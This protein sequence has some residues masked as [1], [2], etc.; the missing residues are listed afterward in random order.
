MTPLMRIVDLPDY[1][2]RG[3]SKMRK[4]NISFSVRVFPLLLAAVLLAVLPG[5]LVS[6]EP[7]EEEYEPITSQDCVTCHERSAHDT[8][9]TDD[10]SHSIHEGLECL[11]CHVDRGTNPHKENPEFYVGCQGCRTCHDQQSEE[12]QAHGRESYGDCEDM[13]TCADCHGDHDVLPSSV[14]QAKT[15][16]I[17]LPQT[18]GKCHED[19]DITAKYEILIDHPIEIYEN[20]VHGKATKGGIYVAATCNDCHSTA[21]TA[22]KIFSPGHPDSTINHFN[23]PKTCGQCHK[24]IEQDFL[25]GIHGELV[26]RGETDAPVCTHCHGE[27]GILAHTDPASPVSPIKLAEM[28]CAPCHDSITLTEKYGLPAGRL[29][30]FIDS[31]HGL[32][33]KAGDVHVANCASCHGV[34]RIKPSSDPTSTIHPENLQDTCGECH[35]GISTAL[36]NAPIHGIRGQGLQTKAA[37]IVKTIYIIAIVII[38]GLMALHWLIDLMRQIVKVIKRPQVRRMRLGELW[39]HHLLMAS[40][41]VLVITGFSLRFG[42]SW[43]TRLFFGWEGG[44]EVRGLIHRGA[45]VALCFATAWHIIYLLTARGRGFL[46]DMMPK[47]RDFFDFVQRILYNL[48]LSKKSPRFK[49]FSYVEKAEYWALIWGNVVMILTGILLWFDNYFV[50]IFPKGVLDVSLVI[51]YYE[52]I[53]AS[54]AILI[55]HLYATVFSPEVYPMNPSWLTGKMPREMFEHE[56]PEAEIEEVNRRTNREPETE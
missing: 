51:H 49:R 16:P 12:Y 40:F 27:H 14:K 9:I 21:G 45:A 33:S 7:Q 32:K 2:L 39:Q 15:H 13:P 41:I 46:K 8:D 50:S 52:A 34:H 26:K 30:S 5:V 22:H 23:I 55:W 48:G 44:F 11:D 25:D 37:G 38:I 36:A 10:L 31:Y 6:Q 19:L 53:L 24:A 54:L 29:T 42:D 1:R 35:P 18:C 43:F 28:T 3:E 17:N 4:P 47:M 20:S 56:H